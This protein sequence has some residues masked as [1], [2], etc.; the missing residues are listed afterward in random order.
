MPGVELKKMSPTHSLAAIV[1]SIGQECDLFSEELGSLTELT[2][3]FEK[4][5]FIN[6][7]GVKTWLDWI[8]SLPESMILHFTNCTPLIVNQLNQ[9]TGFIPAN[10]TIES[11]FIPYICDEC[12]HEDRVLAKREVD[13]DWPAQST[14]ARISAPDSIACSKCRAQMEMDMLPSKFFAFLG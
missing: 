9:V 14:P 3:D 4:V 1:G 11:F 6:S 10:G 7:V 8:K 5:T 2:I 12:G 13:F